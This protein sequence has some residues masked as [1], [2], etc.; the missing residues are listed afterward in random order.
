MGEDGPA[1]P[2]RL[3]GPPV[4]RE[5]D[6]LTRPNGDGRHVV[7]QKLDAAI[8]RVSRGFAGFYF[9]RYDVRAESVEAFQRGEFKI[10]ALNGLTSEATNLYDPAHSLWSGWRTLCREWR[11]A[12][13]IAAAEALLREEVG[14]CGAGNDTMQ[15]SRGAA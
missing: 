10:I 13:E 7:P 6:R 3:V 12:F 2:D 8:D 5:L 4:E 9:G 1:L 15:A 14:A 11:I